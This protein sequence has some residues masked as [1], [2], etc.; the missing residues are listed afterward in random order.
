MLRRRWLSVL[1]VAQSLYHD[2][3]LSRSLEPAT[4]PWGGVMPAH[5]QMPHQKGGGV[6]DPDVAREAKDILQKKKLS[7]ALRPRG[8]RRAT[9]RRWACLPVDP[10]AAEQARRGRGAGAFGAEGGDRGGAG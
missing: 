6:A 3:T 8:D 1:M 7:G 5:G 4:L 9:G 2:S 10:R